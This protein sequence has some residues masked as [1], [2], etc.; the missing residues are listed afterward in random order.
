MKHFLL[1]LAILP[2]LVM[3]GDARPGFADEVIAGLGQSSF[4]SRDGKDSV[5][6]SA[7][8]RPDPFGRFLGAAASFAVAFDAHA[9]GDVFA[10]FGLGLRW[11]LN[12]RWF[13]DLSVMPGLWR[14]STPCNDLGGDFQFR[15]IIGPGYRLTDTSAI[16]FVLSHKSN[17]HIEDR[18]PGLDM[19]LLRWHMAF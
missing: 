14:A 19:V 9:E 12:R 17:A 10:G 11:D 8:Y 15:S 13:L 6:L 18:N 16:S 2:G 5:V 7:E 1:F 4:N 3:T